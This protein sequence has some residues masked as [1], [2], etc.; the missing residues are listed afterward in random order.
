MDK[1]TSGYWVADEAL[2][3]GQHTSGSLMAEKACPNLLAGSGSARGK[4][5]ARSTRKTMGP[6]P[7]CCASSGWD[8]SLCCTHASR[9]GVRLSPVRSK[10][11]WST[12]LRVVVGRSMQQAHCV[13][14]LRPL[15]RPK[16]LATHVAEHAST[17]GR[18]E[19]HSA[20]PYIRVARSTAEFRAA[21]YLR[22]SSFYTYPTSMQRV[23]CQSAPN[24]LM[25]WQLIY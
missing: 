3:F 11:R 18:P 10:P 20:L 1:A 25:A 23:R 12:E 19:I 16:L 4:R 14:R 7:E 13:V 8:D 9:V 21:A 2:S 6:A 15:T 22:A 24:S 17:S 5:N